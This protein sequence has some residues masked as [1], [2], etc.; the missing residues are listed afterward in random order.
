MRNKC[1]KDS[2]PEITFAQPG[3]AMKAPGFTP[4]VSDSDILFA[5]FRSCCDGNNSVSS[6]RVDRLS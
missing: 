5:V 4:T 1:G 3:V 2:R 6:N